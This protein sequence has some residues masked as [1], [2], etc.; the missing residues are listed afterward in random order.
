MREAGRYKVVLLGDAGVGKT[1]LVTQAMQERVTHAYI[2]TVGTHFSSCDIILPDGTCTLQLWDTAGQEL[3]RS[4]VG[5]YTRDARVC[6]IVFDLTNPRS[7]EMLHSWFAFA[8]QNAPGAALVLFGNKTDLETA[9]A[10]SAADAIEFADA[11]TCP[12][13]EGSAR[14]GDGVRHAFEAIA[15]VVFDREDAE[16]ADMELAI[17]DEGNERS[18][19]CGCAQGK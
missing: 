19:G 14:T 2:P 16:Q 12:Y 5:F 13:F 3:Y 6:I 7:F 11:R 8:Q 9:R 4:M 1:S 17:G 15:G 10:V 18:R